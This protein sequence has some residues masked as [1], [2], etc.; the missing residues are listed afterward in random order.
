[1]RV[2]RGSTVDREQL[3]EMVLKIIITVEGGWAQGG[4]M[5]GLNES[6]EYMTCLAQDEQ[7]EAFIESVATMHLYLIWIH[8]PADV[9]TC[10]TEMLMENLED[11][12]IKNSYA[13]H[14]MKSSADRLRGL[15][16]LEPVHIGPGTFRLRTGDVFEAEQLLGLQGAQCV[17]D[18]SA[19]T[20][21][22]HGAKMGF[23]DPDDE[24]GDDD[25]FHYVDMR[26]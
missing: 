24:G 15:V 10:Y 13:E 1:V 21:S 23:H 7:T 3:K 26:H 19:M 4:F 25:G 12:H 22:S 2:F 6:V 16:E 9:V 14:L 11:N 17:I 18:I 5:L 8:T 20:Y